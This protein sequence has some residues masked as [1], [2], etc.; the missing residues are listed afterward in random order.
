MKN[1]RFFLT[2]LY[3][4]RF[5]K[6]FILLYPVYMLMFESSGLSLFEISMLMMIWSVPV[7]LLEIPSGI[8]ADRWSRKWMIVIG[9]SFKLITLILWFFADGFW[10]FALG[11]VFWGIQEAFCSGST[12]A[13]LFDVL[14][15]HGRDDEYEKAAGRGNFYAGV[16]LAASM[17]LGGLAASNGFEL[18]TLLSIASV[19]VAVLLA[20]LLDEASH[21]DELHEGPYKKLLISGITQCRR[22]PKILI[23]L[24]FSSLIIIV[25]GILEEYD[26]LFANRIGLSIVLVGIWGGLRTGMEALG[27]RIAYKFR[28]LFGSVGRLCLLAVA[29]GL[30]LFLS[31]SFF[32]VLLLPLYGLFYVLISGGNVLIES[33][34]QRQISSAHRATVLSVNSLLMNLFSLGLYLLFALIANAGEL[35]AAFLFMAVYTVIVAAVFG[36]IIK[37]R[38]EPEA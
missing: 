32:S 30:L 5:F 6:E 12:E 10:L 3:A 21:A 19:V 18:A 28:N 24:L 25:P 38:K 37:L 34:L 20:L 26:Q 27:S 1:L 17:L 36:L 33:M 22:N 14:K 11:F 7:F 23:L 15:K 31:V 2:T 4:H 35:Q 16:G 9:T 13:L 8:L 29:A